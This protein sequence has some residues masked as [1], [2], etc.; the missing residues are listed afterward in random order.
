MKTLHRLLLLTALLGIAFAF[1][2]KKTKLTQAV[3]SQEPSMEGGEFDVLQGEVDKVAEECTEGNCALKAE[4]GITSKQL[5]AF[6]IMGLSAWMHSF[7]GT[8]LFSWFPMAKAF[9][10]AYYGNMEGA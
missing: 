9:I 6:R 2:V 5:R 1:D 10:R 3:D 4:M 8:G 7:G